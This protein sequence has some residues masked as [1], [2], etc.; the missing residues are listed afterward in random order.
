M[1]VRAETIHMRM[2]PSYSFIFKISH[3]TETQV[4]SEREYF[5]TVEHKKAFSYKR[6]QDLTSTGTQ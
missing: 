4:N 3:E 5:N 6:G 2:C 1:N